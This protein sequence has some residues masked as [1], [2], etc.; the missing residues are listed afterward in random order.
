MKRSTVAQNAL[1][2]L[3]NWYVRF[4]QGDANNMVH[5][6]LDSDNDEGDREVNPLV[7]PLLENAPTQEEIA[8]KVQEKTMKELPEQPIVGPKKT[9]SKLHTP[10][11]SEVDNDF[12]IVPTPDT[13]SSDSSSSDESDEDDMIQKRRYWL[14][15]KRC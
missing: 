8:A 6:D 2:S 4:G 14:V 3:L 12:E 10:K 9:M 11:A 1:L 7:V 13:D 5:S 15:Q